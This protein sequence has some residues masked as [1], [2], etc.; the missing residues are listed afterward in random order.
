MIIKRNT[1]IDIF[2]DISQVAF[3]STLIGPVFSFGKIDLQT[4]AAGSIM[5]LYFWILSLA[6]SK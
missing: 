2:K 6:L 5:T 3:A 4:I 1:L